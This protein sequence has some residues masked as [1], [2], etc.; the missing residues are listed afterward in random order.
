MRTVN[1]HYA[2][3]GRKLA[4]ENPSTLFLI[5]PIHLYNVRIKKMIS[6]FLLF[7]HDIIIL[8]IIYFIFY[9]PLKNSFTIKM[10]EIKSASMSL[11]L[12]NS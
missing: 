2:E 5:A 1:R 9:P 6:D 8:F 11:I 12:L 7:N 3:L 10:E 4:N